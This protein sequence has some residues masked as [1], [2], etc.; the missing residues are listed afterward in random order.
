[1]TRLTQEEMSHGR[2]GRLG[3]QEGTEP[4]LQRRTVGFHDTGP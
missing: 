2:L 3:L 4:R 1:M